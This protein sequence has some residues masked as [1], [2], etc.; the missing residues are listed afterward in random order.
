MDND[1][2]QVDE[3]LPDT[4]E[5]VPFTEVVSV[6]PD[7]SKR[8]KKR[9]YLETGKIPVIDQ[10]QDY[11]GGFTDDESMTFTGELPVVL[12]GDHTK[13]IKFVK[14]H[15]AVGA[16][17][18]KILKPASSY[19]IKFFF[20]LLHSLQ[21]P[22]RGYSR[23]FQFLKKFDLPLAPLNEQRRIVA[24]IEKQFSRLDE[25]V[26]NLK[27]V[28]ANLKRYK[29]SVLKAAVEGKLTEEWRKAN[30][31]VEPAGKLLERIL[32]ERCKKWEEA[33]L[34]KM[35]AKSKVPKSEKWK[36]KFE[37]PLPDSDEFSALPQQWSW[38]FLRNIFDTITDGD[39]QPPPKSDTGIPFLVIG[40]VNTGK[41]DFNRTRFVNKQ[42]Y[43]S[44]VESRKP[45]LGDLLYT[46]VGSYGIPVK[47]DTDQEFC[48]QR[49]IAILKPS[50]H[51]FADYLYYILSSS[52]V[53]NQASEVA[54]GTAQKTVTLK[55]LREIKVPLPPYGEQVHIAKIIEQKFSIIKQLEFSVNNSNIRAQRFRQSI[56]QKAFSGKLVKQDPKDEPAAVLMERIKQEMLKTPIDSKIARKRKPIKRGKKVK[57]KK[58]KRS[59]RDVLADY[60]TG[61]TPE[62]LLTAANY[63]IDE[64]DEFYEKLAQIADQIEEK[65][66]LG[67]KALKWPYEAQIILNLRR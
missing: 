50:Q 35:K 15:F 61:L 46:V 64:V 2:K 53:Y 3:K 23:H 12:F 30:P 32:A 24:E 7:G 6:L 5:F 21:I 33:V 43:D 20:Y 45:K 13:S 26:D 54:T 48:V 66:P 44:I 63:S 10:G 51:I 16:D 28:K 60:P 56:L 36:K 38:V 27:R 41:L 55:G 65:K 9:N 19:N 59:L 49:H 25:A 34:I 62:K 18:I 14:S 1:I 8:V 42:Y 57:P 4:W 39:H 37:D 22:D 11:I 31:D 47:V 67:S 40:N 52:F 58:K 29:V 17:G